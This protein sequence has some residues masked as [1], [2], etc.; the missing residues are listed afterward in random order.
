MSQLSI[1]ILISVFLFS[2]QILHILY[3]N[4]YK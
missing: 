4:K 2:F 3:V 1:F